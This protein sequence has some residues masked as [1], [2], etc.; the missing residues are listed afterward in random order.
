[1][2]VLVGDDM[3]W[4]VAEAAIE[5]YIFASTFHIPRLRQDAMDRLV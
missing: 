5:M 2:Y 1:M 4:K 3:I